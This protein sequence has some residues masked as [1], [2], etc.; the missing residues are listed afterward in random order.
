MASVETDSSNLVEAV[1]VFYD[2]NATSSKQSLCGTKVYILD[3]GIKRPATIGG[4]IT[5]RSA[6]RGTVT[7]GMTAG[8]FLAGEDDIFDGDN[9]HSGPLDD[10]AL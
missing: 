5:I 7:P 8:H 6:E 3:H 9:E 4:L 1:Q 10:T 2:E